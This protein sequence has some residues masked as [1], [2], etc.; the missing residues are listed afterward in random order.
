MTMTNHGGYVILWFSPPFSLGTI[1]RTPCPSKTEQ[2]NYPVFK[3]D[4]KH[5]RQEELQRKQCFP[6]F[7]PARAEGRAE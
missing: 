7:L 2:R 6:H 3:H 5:L 4:G 1:V